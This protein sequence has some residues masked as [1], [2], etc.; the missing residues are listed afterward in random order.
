MT[1][2]LAPQQN[3]TLNATQAAL[4]T[5]LS[6]GEGIVYSQDGE[7]GIL[8]PSR[9]RLD[10]FEISDEDLQALR[11]AG[12]LRVPYDPD[13]VRFD[14]PEVITPVGLAALEAHYAS[15]RECVSIG[16]G[17]R[18]LLGVLEKWPEP[19]GDGELSRMMRDLISAGYVTVLGNVA[20]ITEGGRAYLK[21]ARE[22]EA[23]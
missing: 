20:K 19:M 11:N 4:L 12:M 15:A 17:K 14:P 7:F 23:S 10:V 16:T 8:T 2:T 3:V 21:R 13:A 9:V 22:F 6:A 18:I 5:A 1:T